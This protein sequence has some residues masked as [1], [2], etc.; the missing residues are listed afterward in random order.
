VYAWRVSDMFSLPSSTG[1][2][3]EWKGDIWVQALSEL[4]LN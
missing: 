1:R 2:A 4:V 3:C